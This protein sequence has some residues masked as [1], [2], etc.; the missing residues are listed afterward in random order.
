MEQSTLLSA[1][2]PGLHVGIIMDGNGRWANARGLPRTAGHRA[3]ANAVRRAVEAAPGL[4]I[5]T[6][7]LFAFSSDNWQR[8]SREVST[9]MRLFRT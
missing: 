2:T 8:P 3:G 4:G 7:T 9:L 6:L 1:E 5:R